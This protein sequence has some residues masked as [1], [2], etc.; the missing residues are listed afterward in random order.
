METVGKE[1]FGKSME[2]IS[3]VILILILLGVL[4]LEFEVYDEFD[5]Y[6]VGGESVGML[7]RMDRGMMVV[8][9]EDYGDVCGCIFMLRY[10]E[11][12][13]YEGINHKYTWPSLENIVV[14]GSICFLIR[15]GFFLATK[16]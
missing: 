10:G 12:D 1:I 13:V 16:I 5:L 7:W 4:G 14:Y 9:G 6:G 8:D 15:V 11:G 2:F 3:D